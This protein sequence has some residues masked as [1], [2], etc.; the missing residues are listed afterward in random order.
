MIKK[1]TDHLG[2]FFFFKYREKETENIKKKKGII[3]DE[4]GKI[5]GRS[6]WLLTSEISWKGKNSCVFH[7][8]TFQESN[9]FYHI[10]YADN[11]N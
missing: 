1:M 7:L 6:L 3:R 10:Y 11:P 8:F 5:P 2:T 9:S 4:N